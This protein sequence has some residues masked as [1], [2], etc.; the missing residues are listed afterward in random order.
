MESL[1]DSLK[2]GR[3]DLMSV[4][5]KVEDNYETKGN[6]L[7]YLAHSY[8]T[9][10]M[11]LQNEIQKR[12]KQ[13][14]L[15]W[16]KPDDDIDEVAKYRKEQRDRIRR[17]GG[18]LAELLR[19]KEKNLSVKEEVIVKQKEALLRTDE[20]KIGRLKSVK[21]IAT[22]EDDFKISNKDGFNAVV[23]KYEGKIVKEAEWKLGE[24]A[25]LQELERKLMEQ[26][27]VELLKASGRDEEAARIMNERY[28]E[29]LA[30]KYK[31]VKVKLSLKGAVHAVLAANYLHKLTLN[32]RMH[33]RME[34]F[35][36]FK[37]VAI[38]LTHVRE[39]VFESVRTSFLNV[40]H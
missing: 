24:L 5:E 37:E 33:C 16:I 4:L 38:I 19:Q 7:E 29:S 17:Q 11:K 30:A 1:K 28:I 18:G 20:K 9:N 3:N 40:L 27:L 12:K 15:V 36:E 13:K 21:E 32:T 14:N 23:N 2:F 22:E 26:E 10:E 31:D 35:K 39:W 25:K 34:S 6:A 8:I